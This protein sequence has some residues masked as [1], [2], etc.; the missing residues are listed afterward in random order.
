MF[1][2]WVSDDPMLTGSSSKRYFIILS[3][4][5]LQYEFAEWES[6]TLSGLMNIFRLNK[7]HIEISW[8]RRMLHTKG[9]IKKL[10]TML[11]KP[12]RKQ[13]KI[14]NIII[15]SG[16]LK[17]MLKHLNQLTGRCS[18]TTNI[19]AVK[20]GD[21]TLYQDVKIAEEFDTYFINICQNL[22]N[23]IPHTNQ[24]FNNI[25]PQYPVSL[26]LLTLLNMKYY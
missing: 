6:S 13:R 16:N 24:G 4:F 7:W 25:L 11:T 8:E 20:D 17:S 1:N 9:H 2:A 3:K 5:I 15:I 10:K 23:N 14:F 19:V 22:S 21:D 18:K 12:F 26:F